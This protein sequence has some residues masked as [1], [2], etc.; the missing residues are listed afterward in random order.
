MIHNQFLC[1]PVDIE[2]KWLAY[3][4]KQTQFPI[5]PKQDYTESVWHLGQH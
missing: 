4:I 1:V 2:K 5:S 3:S